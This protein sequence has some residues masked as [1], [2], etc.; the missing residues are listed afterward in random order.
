M[1]FTFPLGSVKVSYIYCFCLHPFS[2]GT[3]DGAGPDDWKV[4]PP[5]DR[6]LVLPLIVPDCQE[7]ELC[8]ETGEATLRER[9]PN[10]GFLKNTECSGQYTIRMLLEETGWGT[11]ELTLTLPGEEL[12]LKGFEALTRLGSV[13]TFLEET[14][15]LT[16]HPS[17]ERRQE[18]VDRLATFFEKELTTVLNSHGCN[19]ATGWVEKYGLSH[20]LAS[21][22]SKIQLLV[23]NKAGRPK[24]T[25]GTCMTIGVSTGKP[26]WPP[27]NAPSLPDQLNKDA[28]TVTNVLRIAL[29]IGPEKAP[30]ITSLSQRSHLVRESPLGVINFLPVEEYVLL[31]H[32]GKAVIF[33]R[34]EGS[35]GGQNG[36]LLKEEV[37][38]TLQT[39]QDLNVSMY[40]HALASIWID[41]RLQ[42]IPSLKAVIQDTL[43]DPRGNVIEIQKNLVE[44]IVDEKSMLARV[45]EEPIHQKLSYGG[46]QTIC[47]YYLNVMGLQKLWDVSF[48]K[49]NV[50]GR[51]YDELGDYVRME[52][53]QR[54]Q[55]QIDKLDPD[56]TV[57]AS[58]R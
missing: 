22:A 48:E 15:A 14:L 32:P 20:F 18:K 12:S 3:N 39:I 11:W 5:N 43:K 53:A 28:A 16:L 31:M 52:D 10:T 41:K 2:K 29:G 37:E 36:A 35:N 49:L 8:R 38:S 26:A 56:S 17:G 25:P 30:D 21:K 51:L 40:V 4:H 27:A 24:Y 1:I 50:L 9:T 19:L 57:L 34:D 13:T 44:E 45:F 58:R 47:D 54:V 33:Y 6:T 42:E 55:R 23:G 7:W 46:I